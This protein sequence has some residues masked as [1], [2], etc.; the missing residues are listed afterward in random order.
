[1]TCGVSRDFPVYGWYSPW[2]KKKLCNQPAVVRVWYAGLEEFGSND[3]CE[4]HAHQVH[5][6]KRP[7]A[8]VERI[9]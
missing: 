2:P 8:R 4:E 5:E 6:L 9:S 7:I 1:M 3:Y